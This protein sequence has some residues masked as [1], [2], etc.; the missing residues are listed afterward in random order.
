MTSTVAASQASCLVYSQ[1]ACVAAVICYK[2][3]IPYSP[4]C[5]PRPPSAN[6]FLT[7]CWY[8]AGCKQQEVCMRCVDSLNIAQLLVPMAAG[9]SNSFSDPFFSV[10]WVPLPQLLPL[11]PSQLVAVIFADFCGSASRCCVEVC[12]AS[13]TELT[14][15]LLFSRL[16][17]L[18]PP[19]STV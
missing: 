6:E 15:M 7:V 16:A 3:S 1:Q 11:T 19:V 4:V 10:C 14:G 12:S 13:K 18:L 2:N 9:A 8:G 17:L 5:R